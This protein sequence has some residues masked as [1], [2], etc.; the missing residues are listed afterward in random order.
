MEKTDSLFQC[1]C[2]SIK[3]KTEPD[4]GSDTQNQRRHR[5]RSVGAGLFHISIGVLII[6]QQCAINRIKFIK[7][8]REH[9][10][11][12]IIF[13]IGLCSECKT[14]F[15]YQNSIDESLKKLN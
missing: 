2:N 8:S 11:Y 15:C 6:K 7:N 9:F 5:L 4:S 12:Y 10:I 3:N 14:P 13:A 1:C